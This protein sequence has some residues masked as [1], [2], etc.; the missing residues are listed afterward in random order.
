NRPTP[1]TNNLRAIRRS[2]GPVFLADL[3]PSTAV[4]AW[5]I[6]VGEPA[7]GSER[8]QFSRKKRPRFAFRHVKVV[9][10]ERIGCTRRAGGELYLR[11]HRSSEW[12]FQLRQ[13][14]ARASI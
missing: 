6:P 1:A 8:G 14:G 4:T 3:S 2:Q 9:G 7:R 10:K 11:L 13:R 12:V 5:I